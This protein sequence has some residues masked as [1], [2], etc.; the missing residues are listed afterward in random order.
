MAPSRKIRAGELLVTALGWAT[1]GT[2][3]L[4]TGSLVVYK[5]DRAEEQANSP[6]AHILSL[7]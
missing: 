2:G 5:R 4:G 6:L 1:V 3:I 7:I